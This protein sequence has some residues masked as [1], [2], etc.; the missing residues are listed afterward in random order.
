MS[1][2]ALSDAALSGAQA[3]PMRLPKGP[4]DN[5]IVG[6]ILVVEANNNLVQQGPNGTQFFHDGQGMYYIVHRV[7]AELGDN[8]DVISV[9]TTFEDQT[10]AA[11]YMP[12]RNDVSGLGECNLNAGRTFGCQFD[13]TP[14]ILSG[15]LRLQ[16]F[17]YMNSVG[18]WRN[19]DANYSG[20][21]KDVTDIEHAVYATLGQEVAHRWGSGLRFIDPRNG[22]LSNKLLGRDMSHWAAF[23]DTDA[24]VMD[25]WDWEP[26]QGGFS[27]TFEVTE[28]LKR[29]ST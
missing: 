28:A 2:P 9:F 8:Y 23:V 1:R 12:L 17:V 6:D 21:A 11:Y 24:S 13:N 4:G 26:I 15:G 22:T 10:V 18:T 19:W 20:A 16:G 7:L 27:G 29:Y 5:T 3:Y 14:S 25:G